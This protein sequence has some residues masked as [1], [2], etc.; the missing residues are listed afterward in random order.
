M[1]VC[2]ALGFAV[3]FRINIF[4]IIYCVFLW[5]FLKNYTKI[6]VGPLHSY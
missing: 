6:S 4:F 5:I 1:H 2:K 3:V